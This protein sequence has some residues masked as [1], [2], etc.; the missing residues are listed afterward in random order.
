MVNA[1]LLENRFLPIFHSFFVDEKLY[2]SYS[3]FLLL[4][5]PLLLKLEKEISFRR[6]N[7]KKTQKR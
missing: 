2:R 6:Q 1:K 3:V 5:D 4:F 7:F